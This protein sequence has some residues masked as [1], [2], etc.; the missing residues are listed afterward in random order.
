MKKIA[1]TG[2]V[3]FLAMFVVTCD[4]GL[5]KGEA[6]VEYTDVVYSEDGSTITLYLDGIG[7]PKTQAQRAITRDLAKMAYDYFEVVFIAD[8]T[9]SSLPV[10][11]RAQWELGQSAGISGVKG[12]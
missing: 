10:Y 8:S 7:V 3:I 4:E 5:P 2:L 6:E 12:C 11:A 9:P 1:I